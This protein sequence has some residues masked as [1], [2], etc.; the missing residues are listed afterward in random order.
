MKKSLPLAV[1]LLFS[2]FL[3]AQITHPV[4][5]AGFGVDAELRA[6]YH[7]NSDWSGNDDW[8]NGAIGTPQFAPG[9]GQGVID[10]N[11]AASMMARFAVD[12]A[13]RRQPFYRTMRVPQY[14]IINSRLWIDAVYIRDYNGQTGNDETSFV[15]S[16]KNGDSPA[17][18][19]AG[20]SP[21][22]AK[23]DISDMLVHVRRAGRTATDSLWF[24]GGMSLQGQVGQR[25]FDFELYQTD[26]FYTRTTGQFS[27]YGPDAGHTS[28]E[29]D[30]SG[31]IIK[32]GD[33]IFSAEYQAQGLTNIEARIWINRNTMSIT[34]AEFDWIGDFD[35]AS[36][37]AQ[38]GYA[39]IR[40]KTAGA[41]YT[42]TESGNNTWAG[43]YGFINSSNVLVTN[44]GSSQF[45]E[46]SVNLTKLGL[47]PMTILGGNAC[48][49]PF[50]RILV[51]TR[52]SASFTSSLSDFIGPFD[53]F[54]T[55]PV[56]A[57]A[58]VPMFCGVMG[59][60]NISVM[61]PLPASVY[62]WKTLDGRIVTGNVGPAITVD[63]TGTYI[64]EQQLLDGCSATA[65]DTVVI[66]FDAGCWPLQNLIV[67][68]EGSILNKKTSLEWTSAANDVIKYYE[69]E[70]SVDGKNF[71]MVHRAN[72]INPE[73]SLA[74]YTFGEDV[75]DFA[76]PFLYYR[77]KVKGNNNEINYSK[78]VKLANAR[79]AGEVLIYPNPAQ[80]FVTIS[81]SAPKRMEAVISI[82]NPAGQ[83][84]YYKRHSLMEGGN[85]IT[86]DET[87]KWATGVYLVNISTEKETYR[88][89]LVV[90][91]TARK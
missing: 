90:S 37:G 72:T 34:P 68:I 80:Q 64:V 31:N 44:Y 67:D 91:N 85:E 13:F 57:Q 53:F 54:N 46:F 47:D 84:V 39:S 69:V 22:L 66:T 27:G 70:R 62:T 17:N 33:V 26:I 88:R 29:L 30:A 18:W 35:G 61:N 60:S 16:N 86:I 42:G 79:M 58:D 25:Y 20:A 83:P 74:S 45:M 73:K 4:I 7:D 2:C 11:G 81:L 14:S 23:T 63:T 40:P 59:A 3:N 87:A 9:T 43:P 21:V 50:R 55:P 56:A 6:N 32:P 51:K 82:I 49:L 48:G 1:L 89:K 76:A 12:P 75:A 19:A 36:V 38:Y 52:T 15:S 28:W 10:T 71:V 41:Y 77:V 8:F 5:R 78:I 24:M 65:A